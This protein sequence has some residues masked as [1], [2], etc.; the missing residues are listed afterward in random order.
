MNEEVQLRGGC[1]CG[2][3]RYAFEG[4][5]ELVAICHCR[6]CQKATGSIAW[7][8]F[9]APRASLSWTRGQLSHY[10]SSAA[11]RRCFCAAC[12][13]PLTIEP[14]GGE[15]IDVGIATL[16]EPAALKPTEQ[17]WIGTRVPWFAELP[18]LPVAGVGDNLP[19]EEAARR[20]PFQHPDHDTSVW[21]PNGRAA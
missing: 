11:A 15:T 9:T 16:D 21:P 20:R 7:A 2:A 19:A 18:D 17:Y 10:R 13:T 12:G 14:A 6:M 5:P 8:F 4:S 3:V 1:Q